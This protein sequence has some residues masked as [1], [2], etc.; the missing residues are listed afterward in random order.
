MYLVNIG[1]LSSTVSY[2]DARRAHT[3]ADVGLLTANIMGAHIKLALHLS[4]SICMAG[5]VTA[6]PYCLVFSRMVPSTT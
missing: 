1:I 5:G 6:L 2:V 4:M 3:G